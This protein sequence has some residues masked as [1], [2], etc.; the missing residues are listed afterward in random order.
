MRA[1][2]IGAVALGLAACATTPAT[3]LDQGKALAK[4]WVGFDGAAQTLDA[5]AVQ[6]V[7]TAPEKVVIASAVPKARAALEAAT[8]AY[9]ANQ[10]ATAQQ[11]VATAAALTAQLILIVKA[12]P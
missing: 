1:L 7:L 3:H 12:H 9:D 10:D 4:A 11:N 8:A 2:L 6:G 5:L